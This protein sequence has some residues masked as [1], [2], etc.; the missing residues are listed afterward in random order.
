MVTASPGTVRAC[1]F[2]LDFQHGEDEGH[3][4]RHGDRTLLATRDRTHRIIGLAIEARI[5]ASPDL[6]EAVYAFHLP[7]GLRRFST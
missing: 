1:P 3:T 2:F 5:A 4:K 7:Y 6:V